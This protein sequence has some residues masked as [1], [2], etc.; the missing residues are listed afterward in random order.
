LLPELSTI[1][2][3][4]IVDNRYWPQTISVRS[5]PLALIGRR[6]SALMLRELDK[7]FDMQP[8]VAAQLSHFDSEATRTFVQFLCL[9]DIR[10]SSS[11]DQ[12]ALVDVAKAVFRKACV[13]GHLDHLAV[14]LAVRLASLRVRNDERAATETSRSLAL[15]LAFEDHLAGKLRSDKNH[16][17]LTESVFVPGELD[18]ILRS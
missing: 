14:L 17:F 3:I 18:L 16:R 15:V 10:A 1:A 4:N 5:L 11:G 13:N 12:M 8:E 2:S 6:T 9:G 7:E